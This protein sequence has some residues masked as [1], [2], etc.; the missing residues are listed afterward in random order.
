M[1]DAWEIQCDQYPEALS[2][3]R[4]LDQAEDA[5]REA[6]AFVADVPAESIELVIHVDLPE[7][8]A[9]AV[10]HRAEAL[11]LA[12]RAQDAASAASRDAVRTLHD[13][14]G[15]SLRDVAT[16]LP[17]SLA[18]AQQLLRESHGAKRRRTPVKG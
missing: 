18:R 15:L 16:I 17:V 4:R 12:Q 14:A 7:D 3:V 8:V 5:Q 9:I 1:D 13:K 10:A 2:L 6:I 11:E